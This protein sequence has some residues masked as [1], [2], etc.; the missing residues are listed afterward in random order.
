M[1]VSEWTE[2]IAYILG[3][4]GSIYILTITY[5]AAYIPAEL[6]ALVLIGVFCCLIV[7]HFHRSDES[8]EYR[9]L[10][11]EVPIEDDEGNYEDPWETVNRVSW[12]IMLNYDD[13]DSFF[14]PLDD[15]YAQLY[16][17]AAHPEEN[18]KEIKKIENR[19]RKQQNKIRRNFPDYK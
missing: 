3:T 6:A 8:R 11:V 5:T 16:V 12:R 9:N 10:W 2:L 13:M 17:L 7:R 14:N 18:Q 19:I 15:L 1:T 4:I